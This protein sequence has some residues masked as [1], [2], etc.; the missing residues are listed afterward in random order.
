M[1]H[2]FD[3]YFLQV[4]LE[5]PDSLHL[6]HRDYPLAPEKLTIT[7]DMLSEETRRFFDDFNISFSSQ[8]RLTQTVLPKTNYVTHV[9]NLQFYMEQGLVLKKIHRAVKFY[10]SCWMATYIKTNTLK[11]IEAQNKFEK[12]F[13]KLLINR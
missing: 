4:D 9:K 3:S 8:T 5:Y 10:Q 2:D 7:K 1:F 13:F 11:R 6:D 12:D